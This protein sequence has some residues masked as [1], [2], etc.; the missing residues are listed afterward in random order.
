MK[1]PRF[2]FALL[3]LFA[4]SI[5]RADSA[6]STLDPTAKLAAARKLSSALKY[7]QGEITLRGGVAKITLPAS[8]RYLDAD[9][10]STVLVKLWGNPSAAGSLGMIVPAEFDP[11]AGRSWAVVLSFAEDGYVKDNDA[12]KI[13]YDKLLKQMQDG[14]RE[15]SQQRVKDGY[16]AIELVG[17]A[18]PPRYDA[19]THKMYWAKELKFGDSPNHTLN[20]NIR[21][22]GRRG[23]LVLNAVASMPQLK[24][25]EAATP[26]LLQMVDFQEG[27]R[28][29]DFTEG[30]DKVAT[31]GIAA[32][33]A[34]GI[35]MKAGLL[36]GLWI[37]I[38]A[39]KKF[40]ILGF[41]ALL[42][43]IKKLWASIRGRQNAA[44]AA[45]VTPNDPAP[46]AV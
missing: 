42:G 35:A 31:Y 7:Q 38:I 45:A 37:A 17:W 39:A 20:Y 32:L 12:E 5:A 25:V 26:A 24:Q 43:G 2:T 13:N 6:P 44:A 23:V 40:I 41:I 15:A 29:A 4:L 10:T 21:M 30:T 11:L 19:A 33:V 9:D 36:K 46:P 18:A 34:G 16:A 1:F 3:V 8:F 14:V 27:H 28:Y 22:L